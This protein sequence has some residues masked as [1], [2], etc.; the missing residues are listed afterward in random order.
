MQD[1]TGEEF[2]LLM[3]VL[4]N[5]PILQTVQGRHQLLGQVLE[6]ADIDKPFVPT[7]PD[8]VDQICSCFKQAITFLSVRKHF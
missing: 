5:L 7:D 6:Q 1:V 3:Y 2:I 8:R 4:Q